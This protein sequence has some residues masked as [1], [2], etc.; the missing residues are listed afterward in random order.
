MTHPTSTAVPLAPSS[1]ASAP[2][3]GPGAGGAD[4]PPAPVLDL[5]QW[6]SM[7]SWKTFSGKSVWFLAVRAVLLVALVIYAVRHGSTTLLV[8][9]IGAFVVDIAHTLV[10][11]YVQ[12][13]GLDLQRWIK[14]LVVGDLDFRIEVSGADEIAMYG[15]VLEVLRQTMARS[16]ALEV[17]ERSLAEELSRNNEVL[18]AT[19]D[20][21]EA[22]QDHIVSQQ[23]LAELGALS[24]GVAHEI[25]NPLQF[26]KNFAQSSTALGEE[27][28]DLLADPD[29]LASEK[30][31][32]DIAEVTHDL[33][34]NMARIKTHS[35]RANRIV[36]GMLALGRRS[37]REFR[38]VDINQLVVE[39]TMLAFQAA[40]AHHPDFNLEIARDLDPGAGELDVAPADLGRVFINIVSN[41]CQAVEQKR[42]AGVAFDPV[43]R[44]TTR[45]DAD[46]VSIA[47]RDN[48]AGMSETV[49]DRMFNPFFTTKEGTGGTGLGMSLSH[50]IVRAHEGTITAASVEGEYAEVTVRLP[51]RRLSA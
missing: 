28:A 50:D 51:H 23:K 14:R 25:R 49:L 40:R 17:A 31:R 10:Q 16:H 24:A 2:R 45:R 20:R 44:L 7:L 37:E 5:S 32:A 34:E 33:T 4:I 19:L 11:A 1:D 36:T 38:P 42:A 43:L 41:A 48:G 8:L 26:I 3:S 35:E 30:V 29:K 9:A 21:L 18:Q 47:F 39:Q 27:L 6:P 13:R 12:V 15:Q 22:T 46:G